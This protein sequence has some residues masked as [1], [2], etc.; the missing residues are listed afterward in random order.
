[1]NTTRSYGWLYGLILGGLFLI[2]SLGTFWYWKRTAQARKDEA[3]YEKI[4]AEVRQLEAWLEHAKS[5]SKGQSS[6]ISDFELT[7]ESAEAGQE[8]ESDQS[9]NP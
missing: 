6:L 8:N 9:K 5:Q 7:D 2:V 1:M 4:I 3:E